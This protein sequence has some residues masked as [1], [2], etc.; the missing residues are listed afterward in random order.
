MPIRWYGPANPMDPIYRNFDRIISLCIHGS[1]FATLNTGLW[2]IQSIRPSYLELSYFT[3]G[4][5]FGWLLHFL[6]VIRLY[7]LS[8]KV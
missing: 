2:F 5:L 4:W 1:F 6:I 3:F 8:G 7:S